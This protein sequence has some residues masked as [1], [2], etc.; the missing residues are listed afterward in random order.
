MGFDAAEWT[1]SK[2][3]EH[4]P[5]RKKREH[6]R[7]HCSQ[8]LRAYKKE[9]HRAEVEALKEE[10]SQAMAVLKAEHNKVLPEMP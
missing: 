8:L 2:K 7:Y 3:H 4:R 9:Q 10:S 1:R 5:H 6:E